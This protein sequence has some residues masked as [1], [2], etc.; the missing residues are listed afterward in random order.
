MGGKIHLRRKHER[1]VA[2]LQS[3]RR[4]TH[5]CWS[6]SE[7]I[8][9]GPKSWKKFTS[10]SCGDNLFERVQVTLKENSRIEEMKESLAQE[11]PKNVL[12]N[13]HTNLRKEETARGCL[14]VGNKE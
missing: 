9:G 7:S 1:Q 10:R 14:V 5:C 3:G 6:T 12:R 4:D 2:G 8:A 11:K 13:N